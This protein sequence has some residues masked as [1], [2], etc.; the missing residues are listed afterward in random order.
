MLQMFIIY[1]VSELFWHLQQAAV[2]WH[3]HDKLIKNKALGKKI[4]SNIHLSFSS[5]FGLCHLLT[6]LL[7]KMLA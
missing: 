1:K 3:Q 7:Y 6:L 5:V 2:N 4:M